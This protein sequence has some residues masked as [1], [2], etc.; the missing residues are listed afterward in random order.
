MA[1]SRLVTV[2]AFVLIASR[3][4]A[5]SLTTFVCLIA[6]CALVGAALCLFLAAS[7][8]ALALLI[9]AA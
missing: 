5:S 3:S 1:V 6:T 2:C 4:I 7:V 8:L 9:I